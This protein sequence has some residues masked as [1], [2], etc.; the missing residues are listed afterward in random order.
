[1]SRFT[2]AVLQTAFASD[3][4]SFA[5]LMQIGTGA[6]TL[7]LTDSDKDIVDQSVTYISSSS[8]ISIGEVSESSSPTQ[9]GISLNFS[10]VDQTMISYFLGSDYVG[11]YVKV[12]RCALNSTHQSIGSFNYFVGTIS[13]FKIEDTDTT[14]QVIVECKSHWEDFDKRNGRRTNHNS[15]QLHFAGDDGFEFGAKTIDDIKWGKA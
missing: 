10:G 4:Y 2:S 6:D 13:N 3:S 9:G 12:S 8:V 14:S 5:T 11:R 15:Q 1:M 7:L